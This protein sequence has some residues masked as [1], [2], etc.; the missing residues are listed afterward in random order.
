MRNQDYRALFMEGGCRFYALVL[1]E[2]LGLPL[3]YACFPDRDE[4]GHVFVMKDSVCY[5]YDGAKEWA[6]V[7]Q[8]YAGWCDEK[9]R[10]A[11]PERIYKEMQKRGLS[12]LEEQIVEIARREFAKRR[13]LYEQGNAA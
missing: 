6:S 2:Q 7:A 4:F 13:H 3:F 11:T 12:D 8:Q 5:D 9:P 1:N 10:A